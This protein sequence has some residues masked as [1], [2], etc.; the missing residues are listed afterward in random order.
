MSKRTCLIFPKPFEACALLLSLG[1]HIINSHRQSDWN[2][3][4][5]I[6]INEVFY[7]FEIKI[8]NESDF[9]FYNKLETLTKDKQ[10]LLIGSCGLMRLKDSE[11]IDESKIPDIPRILINKSNPDLYKPFI[12]L[13]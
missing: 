12:K 4:I 7:E 2:W 13:V 6:N 8:I 1:K 9:M 10:Y 11:M 5:V 3:M